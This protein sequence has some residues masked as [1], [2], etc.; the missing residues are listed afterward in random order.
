MFEG[1]ITLLLAGVLASHGAFGWMSYPQVLLFGTLGAITGDFFGYLVGRFFRKS[2]N[3]FSFYRAAQPRIEQL[4]E[5]FGPLSIFV[6]KYI[7]GIRAAWCIF[8]GVS[9]T[10]W[11]RFLLYDSI[12]CFLWV[13]ILSGVGRLFGGAVIGL[14][15]DFHRVGIALLVIVIIGVIGF[16]LFERF[17]ISKK[18]EEVDAETVHKLEEAAHIT[19]H[20][21]TEGIQER[22]HLNKTNNT[23]AARD[24]KTPQTT[25]AEPHKAESD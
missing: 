3:N 20:D 4:T 22:L 14:I 24:E 2:V 16:Y 19:I 18:V 25:Q 7:Y 5:K 9:G 15:G 17:W 23:P 8:Y 11:W 13:L 6:S 21:F 12:S 10:P 1:D